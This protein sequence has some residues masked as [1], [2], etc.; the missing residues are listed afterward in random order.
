LEAELSAKK[1][2]YKIACDAAMKKFG[3]KYPAELEDGQ[4]KLF[5]DYIAA[6]Q[7]VQAEGVL[8]PSDPTARGD[9]DSERRVLNAEAQRN[10]RERQTGEGEAEG[11]A[12]GREDASDPMIGGQGDAIFESRTEDLAGMDVAARGMTPPLDETGPGFIDVEIEVITCD[13]CGARCH[14]P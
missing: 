8:D 6:L 3:V 5:F 1:A 11:Q 2:A 12:S 10:Y 7:K 4:K 13:G 14:R 9:A